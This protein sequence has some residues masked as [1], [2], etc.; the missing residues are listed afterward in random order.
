M[1]DT[2]IRHQA[3][4][5]FTQRVMTAVISALAHVAILALVVLVPLWYFT[6]ELPT[7]SAI[8]A[9]VAPLPPPPP[10]PPPPP[11][12]AAARE[13]RRESPKPKADSRAF[14]A[15]VEAPSRI[16]PEEAVE[17]TGTSGV[18]GGVEGGIPG[19]VVGGIVGGLQSAAPP[20]PPLPRPPAPKPAPIR[21]GGQIMAPTLL[22]RVDP[23]YPA[24]AQAAQ[25]EGIVILEAT[26]N[27]TGSVE[28]LKVLRSIG[29]LDAAAIAAVKQWRYSPLSL[30]GRP[31][32]FVLTVTVQFH[33]SRQGGR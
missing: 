10:P 18:L 2:I 33:L 26:V 27:E 3:Q 30:N 6:P 25:I 23:E 8:I 29:P 4:S 11:A 21:I 13:I 12:P 9:F 31:T 5:T 19:G 22:V 7:P 1:F 24:I 16:Q 17:S 20:P 28:A 32:S 14:A 15:P